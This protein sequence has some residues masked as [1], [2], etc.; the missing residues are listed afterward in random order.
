LFI[1]LLL[2]FSK[3]WLFFRRS[4]LLAPNGLPLEAGLADE[5]CRGAIL[6]CDAACGCEPVFVCCDDLGVLVGFIFLA[7]N[8][9]DHSP[10]KPHLVGIKALGKQILLKIVI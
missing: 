8:V 5:A 9:G 3:N 6:I 2:L 4:Y 10:N 1:G 7:P